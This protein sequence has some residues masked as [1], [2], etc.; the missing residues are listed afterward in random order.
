MPKLFTN[1]QIFRRNVPPNKFVGTLPKSWR[2]QNLV[3]KVR[4]IEDKDEVKLRRELV[5][6]KS[7]AQLAQI[8]SFGDFPVPT[9]IQNMMGSGKK[10]KSSA[11]P[12]KKR[13]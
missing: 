2:E 10:D 1:Q 6:S 11:E 13:R 4:E 5:Q 9:R 3:T 7:P 8:T 12:P